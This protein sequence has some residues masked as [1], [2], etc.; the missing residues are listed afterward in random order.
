MSDKQSEAKIFAPSE[1]Q[2]Y[3]CDLRFSMSQETYAAG[4][5]HSA[6]LLVTNV[7]QNC[8]LSDTCGP[9]IAYLY[10]QFIEL[11][12]K[13]ILRLQSRLSGC[14][15]LESGHFIDDLWEKIKKGFDTEFSEYFHEGIEVTERCVTEYTIMDPIGDAFRYADPNSKKKRPSKKPPKEPKIAK[16]REQRSF[17]V[18]T[19]GAQ[20][21]TV[22]YFLSILQGYLQ[23]KLTNSSQ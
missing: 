14:D 11:M 9:S 2:R 15:E 21:A 4:Y 17:D 23:F 5:Y 19:L 7:Y 8:A 20:M 12:F 18:V 1:N 22:E 10:R 6:K 16:F 3:S 13:D